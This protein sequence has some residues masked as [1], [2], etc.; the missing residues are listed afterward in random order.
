MKYGLTEEII[1]SIQHVFEAFPPVDKAILYGSRAKGNYKPGSDIDL[2]LKG[3][4]LNLTL[5]NQVSICLDD[6]YLPYTFDLSI[7]TQIEN[8]ELLE[9]IDRVGVEFYSRWKEYNT[10]ELLDANI[11]SI[12]DGYRAKNIE[13]S[14]T[15]STG[16]PFAR[17][18][19]IKG[20]F[21]FSNTD[22]FPLDDLKKVGEKISKVGDTVFTSKGTVGRF[23][24]VNEETPRF[25]YSPQLC[26]WRSLDPNTLSSR[27]LYYWMQGAEFTEQS[28]AVKG[29]TDMADYVNLSDQRKMKI[30]LPPLSEQIA[31]ASILSSLD[32]KIDLLQRQNK[33]LEQLAETLFRQWFVEEA[34]ESWEVGKLED[35]ISVIGGTTPSTKKPE[36]WDGNIN[37]TSPRDLSNAASVFLFTTERKISEAGLAQIGSGLLP[38]GTVLLS[39]RAP[40]GY[41]TITEIPVAINQGYI[42]IV[43]DKIVSNYFIFLWCRANMETIE[44]AG[45]G[46]VFQEIS[47]SSFKGLE[48]II[49][50][51]EKLGRFDKIVSLLFQKIKSNQ[52]QIRTL[53]QTRDTLLPKLMSG[54]V[55]V[56]LSELG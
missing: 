21:D 35:V 49:P 30:T 2:T 27:F 56:K 24:Y 3:T 40:I 44:N 4:G 55:R 46:S 10:S 9:H 42:A 32:D 8:R 18:G 36:F 39:S 52:I 37:W 13:L 14:A 5:I 17:A 29:Q 54:E 51:V 31:I 43:C 20:I 47:K 11:L 6:L 34:E 7:Y 22:Y 38:V 26:F 15:L 19:N 16:I 41:L 25:I 48:I 33:T 1:E 53:T 45:N 23:A 12:G 50:S 28:N